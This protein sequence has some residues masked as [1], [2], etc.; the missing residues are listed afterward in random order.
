MR[1]QGQGKAP[2]LISVLHNAIA[3]GLL[4]AAAK[5]HRLV[6]AGERPDHGAVVHAFGPQVGPADR[7][8]LAAE[9][10]GKFRLNASI[11]ALRIGLAF[12]R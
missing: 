6:A 1:G 11:S 2:R 4:Q 5:L 9:H 7:V 3:A 8:R 12:L 10:A